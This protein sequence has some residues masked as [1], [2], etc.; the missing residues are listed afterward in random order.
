[1][2]MRQVEYEAGVK[3][4]GSALHATRCTLPCHTNH[5]M[6]H[7]SECDKVLKCGG[8][9]CM[10]Q[11]P[12]QPERRDQASSV[13]VCTVCVSCDIYTLLHSLPSISSTE[14][15]MN[16]APFSS[17]LSRLFLHSSLLNSYVTSHILL[18]SS[19]HLNS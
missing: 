7:V 14:S 12:N 3:G 18:M 9:S 6:I 13:T 16:R 1:M 19:F 2:K 8:W 10:S 15:G 5:V 17:F 11:A 4:R